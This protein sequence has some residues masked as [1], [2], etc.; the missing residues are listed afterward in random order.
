MVGKSLAHYQILEK[1]GEGG[2]GVVYKARDTHLDRFVAIK[3]LPPELVADPERKRRF[4]Q[5]AK[6]ASALNHPN[7]ITVHD[8]GKEGGI[9]FLVMECLSGQTLEARLRDGPLPMGEVIEYATQAARALG[10]AHAASIVHRDLKPGNLMLTK[11]GS[12]G[13]GLL[14]VLDFGL[15]KLSHPVQ[16][17]TDAPTQTGAPGTEIGAILGTAPYMSPEQAQGLDVDARSDVFSLGG[18]IYEML[19]GRRPFGEGKAAVAAILCGQAAPVRSLRPDAPKE[20]VQIVERALAKDQAQ[21]YPSCAEMAQD[22]ARLRPA[23]GGRSRSRTILAAAGI[24]ALVITLAGWWAWRDS[25]RRWASEEALP[26]ALQ[27]AERGSYV[28]S[29]DLAQRARLLIPSDPILGQLLKDVSLTLDL[30]T[31]P[32]GASVRYREYADPQGAWRQL[33]TTPIRNAQVPRGFFR[34]HI[35]AAGYAPL[36]LALHSI[37]GYSVYSL[38]AKI[39]L[40]PERNVPEGMVYVPAG[41]FKPPLGVLGDLPVKDLPEFWIDRYEVT[42]RQFKR[43]VDADGYEKPEYWKYPFMRNGK[44]LSWKEAMALFVDSTGRPGPSTWEAGTYSGDK[45]DFPVSG[46][47]WYEAAAYAE[48]A[49]KRLPT[50]YQWHRAAGTTT[51]VYVVPLSNFGTAGPVRVGERPDLSPAGTYDMAG[52]VRE[53]TSTDRAGKRYILGGAWS[54]MRYAFSWAVWQS[55]WDRPPQDGFRC[56]EVSAEPASAELPQL[57]PPIRDPASVKPVSDETFRVFRGMYQR[58]AVPLQARVE[59]SDDS[60]PYWRRE[61]VSY[62]TGMPEQR[63]R[64]MLVLPKNPRP[65]LQVVVYIPGS[66]SLSRKSLEAS[67]V[68]TANQLGFL[69]KSG[70]AVVFPTIWGTFE[71]Q[72]GLE[73]LQLDRDGVTHWVHDL[74]A[75]LDYLASRPEFDSGRFAY[76]GVSMGA[77]LATILLPLEPRIKLGILLDGGLPYIPRAPEADELNFAPRVRVPVL[78][79]NGR[80]DQLWP[81]QLAQEPLFRLLGSPDKDKKHVLVDSGHLVMVQ[82]GEVAHLVLDWLDRYLGKVK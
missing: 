74:G 81:V 68:R 30:D 14:K 48:F 63:M 9:D 58:K 29:F 53:W 18:V 57:N 37:Q 59:S 28:A 7:I 4:V 43:F 10:D 16:P 19:T 40:T 47:S 34:W 26:A 2:M 77:R 25:R 23:T 6:A 42:N 82:R 31:M 39:A 27:L 51:A 12:A 41:P 78:M 1:L 66:G 79:I 71:R 75:T 24:A 15:A 22:L 5:E 33:G 54:D 20:L 32:E 69:M 38:P 3:V 60:A 80:Y 62:E 73:T 55:P 17:R 76:L 52:N 13:P 36:D 72:A 67:S 64:T 65:P 56:V 21:R 35:E 11:A 8:I 44:M 61:I 70:R 49:G 45:D 46:V 50:Y